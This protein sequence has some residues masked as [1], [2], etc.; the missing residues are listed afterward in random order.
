MLPGTNHRPAWRIIQV[1]AMATASITGLATWLAYVL[2]ARNA[3]FA[4]EPVLWVGAASLLLE[5]ALAGWSIRAIKA[6]EDDQKKER[7]H[8]VATAIH[9]V[10]QPLQAATLFIDGLLHSALSPQPLKAAQCLDQSVQSVR[11]ILDG[12]LD[13]SRIDA[14]VV[15][16]KQQTFSLSPL[17]HV[18]EAEFAPQAISKNFR[19]CFYTPPTDICVNS[20]PQLVQLIL[21][22]LLIHAIAQTQQGGV[23]LGLRQRGNRVLIQV[24]DTHTGTP[25]IP[26]KGSGRYRVLAN[27]V[28]ELL[29]SPLTF[30]SKMGRGA[31]CTLTLPL[32]NTAPKSPTSGVHI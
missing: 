20:D 5:L 22:N 21:R 19:F 14:G 29:Q 28:A 3:P 6:I 31:V 7:V 25:S 11:H 27:R 23:L 30:E 1:T 2:V 17:L 18:L 13:T 26:G 24:W 8:F 9:D 4:A 32:A 16:V 10:R 12:L 15:P